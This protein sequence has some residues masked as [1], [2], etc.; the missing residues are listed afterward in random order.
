MTD[1]DD[2]GYNYP[3]GECKFYTDEYVYHDEKG[4]ELRALP[5]WF[6]EG[7]YKANVNSNSFINADNGALGT[8]N[9]YNLRVGLSYARA[10][11]TLKG[12]E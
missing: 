8:H 12:V 5:H 4:T 11:E 6:G 10:R 1:G 7:F 2:I 3:V 9:E